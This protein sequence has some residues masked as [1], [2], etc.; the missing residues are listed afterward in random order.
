[1]KVKR[2]EKL[3]ICFVA[4][5]LAIWAFDTFYYTPQSKKI[6]Q[7]KEEVKAADLK[8]KES[9]IFMRSV[10]TVETEVSR[11]EKELQGLSE[12]TLKGKEFRAFLR[13]L[14]ADSDRLQM[15]MISLIPSEEKLPTPEGKKAASPLQYKRVRINLTL[16]SSFAALDAYLKEIEDL[17]FLVTVDTLQMERSEEISPY[18][19]VTLGLSVHIIS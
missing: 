3:L 7:L 17:P 18:L 15:K 8:L 12:R 11:L 10:E 1:M 19:K 6:A 2:R 9:A 13:H 16:H 4:I 5:A 14:A